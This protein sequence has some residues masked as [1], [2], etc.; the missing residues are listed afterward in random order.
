GSGAGLVSGLLGAPLWLQ[1]IVAGVA[2]TVL[3][4]ILRPPL[5]KRL[6]RGEDPT[7]SNI[8][9]II[10][11]PGLALHEITAT[12][13]QV[14]LSNGDIW[15]ARTADASAIPPGVPIAVDAI[16]GATAIVRPAQR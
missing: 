4:L 16:E 13:G 6:H 15:T 14:K 12:S 5:L 3:I 8:D 11:L 10:G 2:A 7:K 1:F 9:A